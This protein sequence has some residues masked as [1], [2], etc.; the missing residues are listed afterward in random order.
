MA[1]VIHFFGNIKELR[2]LLLVKINSTWLKILLLKKSNFHLADIVLE[3]K[4]LFSC[5]VFFMICNQ[6][7]RV[8]F[9]WGGGGLKA[10]VY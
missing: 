5:G 7:C 4:L 8:T 3:I 6:F 9:F 10:I 1:P 2:S